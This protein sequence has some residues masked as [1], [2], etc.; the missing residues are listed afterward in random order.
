MICVLPRVSSM[1]YNLSSIGVD[2]SCRH[3][4]FICCTDPLPG[5]MQGMQS[6]MPNL[7]KDTALAGGAL[8]FAAISKK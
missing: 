8:V 4:T 7:L 6:A 2:P 5:M 1:I 3:V